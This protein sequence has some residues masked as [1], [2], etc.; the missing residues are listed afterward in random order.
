[1]SSICRTTRRGYTTSILSLTGP[2]WARGRHRNVRSTHSPRRKDRTSSTLPFPSVGLDTKPSLDLNRLKIDRPQEPGPARGRRAGR[3]SWLFWLVL[4]TLLAAGGWIFHT[5]ILTWIDSVRLP[6]VA[7]TRVFRDNAI[8]AGAL[9]GAAAN[10]YIVASTRAALSA[11][12]PGRIVEINVREGQAVKKGFV[13]ARLYDKEYKAAVRR[14]EADVTVGHATLRRREAEKSAAEADHRRLVAAR[15]A[16]QADVDQ[17]ESDERLARVRFARSTKLVDQ[18]AETIENLDEAKAR[19]ESADAA[20]TSAEAHLA[21]AGA[22]V[23]QGIS[24]VALGEAGTLEARA[25]LDVLQASLELAQATLDKTA[26]RAPFDGIVVLKDAEVGEVVSPN[27][28]AGGSARGSVVTMVDF[29]S[30]EVQAEVPETTIAEVRIGAPVRVFLDAFPGIPY[31]GRVDRIWPTADRQKATIEVRGIFDAPDERLR[32]EM[33]VRV[34]FLAEEPTDSPASAAAS[35][36]PNSWLLVPASAIVDGEDG[37]KSVFLLVRDVVRLK[38]LEVGEERGGRVPVR[39]G[40]KGN[41][42]IVDRPPPTL[43]DGDR[44]RFQDD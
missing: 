13:V 1:M 36:S 42:K 12:T 18:G 5:P 2:S 15:D 41:E 23:A 4:V 26:V 3:S 44:V 30:L 38:R 22:A 39:G 17:A 31:T 33:G 35:E 28:Q 24:L 7:V 27:S 34:V 9:S 21:A 43:R 25:A 29:N 16:A 32:P 8:A 10:G 6:E 19:L 37:T 11:D 14:A 20:V 40:L